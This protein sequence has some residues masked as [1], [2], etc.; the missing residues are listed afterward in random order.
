LILE[1]QPIAYEPLECVFPA[2][3][4]FKH[5]HM[6]WKDL[7]R[8]SWKRV[9]NKVLAEELKNSA[10]RIYAAC[11]ASGYGRCDF[12]LIMATTHY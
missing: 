6:K 8:L 3:E 4:D 1:F 11:S 5:F 10:K 9:E 7:G 2:G 12:R